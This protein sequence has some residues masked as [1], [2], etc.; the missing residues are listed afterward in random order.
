MWEHEANIGETGSGKTY[1]AIKAALQRGRRIIYINPKPRRGAA[2]SDVTRNFYRAWPS[3][4]DREDIRDMVNRGIP[5][6]FIPDN[7]AQKGME[8]LRVVVDEAFRLGNLTM[9][10]D[11]AAIHS[12]EGCRWSPAIEV[13]ERGR[14]ARIKG[15]FI[16]QSP[17]ALSKRVLANCNILRIFRFNPLWTSAYLEG[18]QLDSKA[19][20]SKLLTAPEFSYMLVKGGEVLEPR[21]E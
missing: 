14:E 20:Y 7:H 18:K 9:I 8:Q 5:I 15:H 4:V 10:F 1:Q 21:R 2:Y 17:S 13:A 11:E 16:V 6:E 3:E 19:L 12:P